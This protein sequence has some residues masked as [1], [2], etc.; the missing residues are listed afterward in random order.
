MYLLCICL[1]LANKV[2]LLLLLRSD[3]KRRASEVTTL[4]STLFLHGVCV[5][6]ECIYMYGECA[7][8]QHVRKTPTLILTHNDQCL[9]SKW[10]CRTCAY[11]SVQL[12]KSRVEKEFTP[13]YGGTETCIVITCAIYCAVRSRHCFSDVFPCRFISDVGPSVCMR[14]T[15]KLLNYNWCSLVGIYVGVNRRIDESLVA[16]NLDIWNKRSWVFRPE[17]PCARYIDS[18]RDERKCLRGTNSL[19]FPQDPKQPPGGQGLQF[20]NH[21]TRT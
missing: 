15:A 19:R 13:L 8:E 14:G 16:F 5:L 9:L 2:L 12:D 17:T 4:W 20:V 11:S 10:K 6:R 3:W 18:R 7:H 1:Y 21:R